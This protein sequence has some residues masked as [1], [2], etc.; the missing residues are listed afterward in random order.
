MSFT[1]SRTQNSCKITIPSRNEVYFKGTGDYSFKEMNNQKSLK[2]RIHENIV[3]KNMVVPEFAP[4][5]ISYFNYGNYLL[6]DFPFN[7]P[8]TDFVEFDVAKAYY[9]MAYNL[10]YIDEDMYREYIDLKKEIRLRF[11]G[12]IATKKRIYHYEKGEM[13]GDPEIKEDKILRKV[14]FHICK[15]TDNCLNELMREVQDDF[16][17]YYVDGIYLKKKDYSKVINRISQKY[18]LEFVQENVESITKVWDDNS[19]STKIIITKF[20]T[21][22]EAYVPKEFTIR[23]K[24]L[25]ENGE[26]KQILKENGQL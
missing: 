10:G 13:V 1:V 5:D 9:K 6:R 16:I 8:M 21:K 7:E 19:K 11:L 23:A 18:K 25:I 22:K 17:M 14:W 24:D 12:S 15:E 20:N 3:K 2:K 4:S 26:Y